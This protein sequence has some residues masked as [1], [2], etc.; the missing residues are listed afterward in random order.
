MS[1]FVVDLKIPSWR[2]SSDEVAWSRRELTAATEAAGRA[3]SCSSSSITCMRFCRR[4]RGAALGRSSLSAWVS[5]A[6]TA[7]VKGFASAFERISLIFGATPEEAGKAGNSNF[8][9]GGK[10]CSRGGAIAV[11]FARGGMDF[12]W[13]AILGGKPTVNFK[14]L[15]RVAVDLL[16]EA[17][18]VPGLTFVDSNAPFNF[19]R[20][21][22]SFSLE[23]MGEVL[24]SSTTFCENNFL[25]L[26]D[27]VITGAVGDIESMLI[28]PLEI[29]F[30]MRIITK[31]DVRMCDFLIS[32]LCCPI[33]FCPVRFA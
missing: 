1:L 25:V 28:W 30:W 13:R 8:D 23:W 29:E 20:C 14:R 4:L 11:E 21:G 9:F 2:C 3:W 33:A 15:P 10:I 5:L 24:K 32:R 12:S 19:G 16:E 26:C 6:W 27:E 31:N 17:R 18:G 22:F 7:T